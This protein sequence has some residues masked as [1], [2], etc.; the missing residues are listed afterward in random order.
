MC[1]FIKIKRTDFSIENILI[2]V[3][4]ILVSLFFMFPVLWVISLSF[5]TTAEV[6]AYPPN[7]IPKNITINNFI[8]VLK[9]T[10]M[11]QYILNSFKLVL[12]TVVGTLLVAI[13][14]G[15][16]FS[17]FTFKNKNK[18][19]FAIL[20]FQMVSPIIIGIPLYRYYSSLGLLNSYFGLIMAYIAIQVPF[21]TFLLKGGFDNIP[22]E[23]DEAAKID[24]ATRI[25]LLTKIIVP[26]SLPSIA[27]AII[28]ISINSWA[29]F[30]LPYLLLNKDKFYPVSVGILMAQGTFQQISTHLIEAASVLS[31]IPAII[32]V[33][34]LQKFI[35]KALTSGAVKG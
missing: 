25:Q 34:F 13:P 8:E 28:F 4:Y 27:S 18:L 15:Y 14:A 11:F 32:L 30:L 26:V 7:L 19:L 10:S 17:R 33:L 24:G 12:F 6:F 3:A 1:R 9:N 23:I 20:V 16:S 31:L 5:K 29:Q 22:Q 21:A 2:W 35:L